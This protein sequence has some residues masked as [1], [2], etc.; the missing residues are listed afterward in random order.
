MVMS[1]KYVNKYIKKICR[2]PTWSG[3]PS[4]SI[5]ILDTLGQPADG[6]PSLPAP[7]KLRGCDGGG[8]ERERGGGDSLQG[9]SSSARTLSPNKNTTMDRLCWSQP[10]GVSQH[11]FSSSS[12]FPGFA[13]PGPF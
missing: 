8:E 9:L 12:F 4:E 10:L 7:E 1:I 3:A 11:F 5:V 13:D 6:H 2:I